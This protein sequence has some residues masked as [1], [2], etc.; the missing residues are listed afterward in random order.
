MGFFWEY[1]LYMVLPFILRFGGL[2]ANIAACVM[3]LICTGT[4]IGFV[5]DK[6]GKK[7][8]QFMN[9]KGV[10]TSVFCCLMLLFLG[11]AWVLDQI[12]PV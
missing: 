1:T 7:D 4:G 5:A 9:A 12:S 3:C 8:E 11:I 10:T 2:I 6:A